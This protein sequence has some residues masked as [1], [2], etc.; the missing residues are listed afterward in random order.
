MFLNSSQHAALVAAANAQAAAAESAKR[1]AEE[2]QRLRKEFDR[3]SSEI[4]NPKPVVVMT[5]GTFDLLHIDHVR[6]LRECRKHG[7]CLIVAMNS[8]NSSFRRKG[9]HPAIPELDRRAMLIETGLADRV[10][11][12][13]DPTPILL[14]EAWKPDVFVVG[15]DYTPEQVAGRDLIE[16]YGGRVVCRTASRTVSSSEIRSR[17]VNG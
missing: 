6:H 10:M 14:I 9:R 7:N 5:S 4:N 3:I 2:I 13:D 8:D 16:S 1:Q 11:I 17:I 15:S 12:F